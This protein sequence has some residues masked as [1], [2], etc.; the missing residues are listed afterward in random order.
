MND[1]INIDKTIREKLEDFSVAPPS[2]VWDNIQGQMAVQQRKKRL[3]YV[4]WIAAAAV[5]VFA[6]IAG[7]V[8]NERADAIVPE[9]VEQPK[10]QPLKEENKTTDKTTIIESANENDLLVETN[11]KNISFDDTNSKMGVSSL[12]SSSKN[13]GENLFVASVERISYDTLESLEAIFMLERSDVSFVENK[14]QPSELGL[15]TYDEMLIAENIKTSKKQEN[16][17]NGWKIGT[18]IS[19]GYAA[20]SSSHSEQYAQNMTY[21]GSDGSAN[22]GAGFSVQYKTNKRLRIESGV[23]YSQNGQSSNNSGTELFG[24]NSNTDYMVA[25]PEVIADAAPGFSNTVLLSGNGIAMNSTAGVINMRSAPKG[26]MVATS[27]ESV[28][29]KNTN[30]LTTSGEFSQVFQ[31]VEVPLYL[32]YNVLDKKFGVE[33]MGG[34]NAGMVV[35]NNAFIDNEYGKQN[36]GS[37]DDI[38]TMNLSGTI[39]VGMNYALGKHFSLALEPRLNYF[40]NSIN[41]NP[42]VDYRPYRVGVFTGIYYE[43]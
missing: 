23:Y 28:N 42:D 1:K 41:S 2:H 24:F 38:S 29:A 18:L 37:T 30:T 32:R 15:S 33:I 3:A 35:G 21:S 16:T 40:L 17:E 4:S 36:I 19:P 43:F 9:T 7:W 20:H 5:V 12:S 11:S 31:F 10:V 14:Q 34:I 25:A 8:L 26:A 6:F 22:V 39:G 27:A 13:I